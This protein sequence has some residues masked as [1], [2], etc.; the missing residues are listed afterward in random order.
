MGNQWGREGAWGW[1]QEI[2]VLI[3]LCHKTT[4]TTTKRKLRN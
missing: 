2:S 4:A 3:K 1:R